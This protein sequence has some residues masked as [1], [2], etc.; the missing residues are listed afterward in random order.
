[1]RKLNLP[2]YDFRFKNEK[3]KVLIFDEIRKKFIVLNQ[4]EWVRQ[5]F[6]RYL[7]ND[8]KFPASLMAVEK[9][10]LINNQPQRFD[11]LVYNRK[12]FPHTIVEF[13]SPDVKITQQTFDQA[14][15][16]NMV[17]K[18][19]YIIVS[20]GLQHFVCKI[21]YQSNNYKFLNDVPVFGE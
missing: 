21:D 5:N 6:I 16:Y 8:K 3:E 2:E 17:L 13:K 4:E 1:M 9:K 14:V 15:R 18:V 11:L 10:V 12:G 20:N 19:E 7:I